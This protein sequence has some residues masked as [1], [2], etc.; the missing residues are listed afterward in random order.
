[1]NITTSKIKFMKGGNI[2]TLLQKDEDSV[3]KFHYNGNVINIVTKQEVLDNLP[4]LTYN[5]TAKIFYYLNGELI[6][7][8]V[9]EDIEYFNTYELIFNN[10]DSFVTSDNINRDNSF[11]T[12]SLFNIEKIS[13]SINYNNSNIELK[14]DDTICISNASN[15]SL[16]TRAT[17][18]TPNILNLRTNPELSL[19]DTVQD[20]LAG[21]KLDVLELDITKIINK[22][23]EATVAENYTLNNAK[24]QT[25]YITL[26]YTEVEDV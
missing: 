10:N 7:L 9:E 23:T 20:S 19:I 5:D 18:E 24:A 1:M 25:Y 14:Y 12:L 16:L 26:P 2:Y 17:D 4:N 11:T 15:I 13:D 6:Q 22:V 8:A 3:I 21:C